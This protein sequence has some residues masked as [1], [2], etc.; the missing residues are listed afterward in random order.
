MENILDQ[1]PEL[2]VVIQWVFR[3]CAGMGALVFLALALNAFGAIKDPESGVSAKAVADA[4]GEQCE[5]CG[6]KAG[7]PFLPHE[8][9]EPSYVKTKGH[10]GA[11]TKGVGN[12]ARVRKPLTPPN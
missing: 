7:R 4:F 9:W 12:R 3:I 8:G 1:L 2:S 6:H 5:R 11:E 10:K